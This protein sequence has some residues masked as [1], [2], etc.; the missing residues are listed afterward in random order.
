VV[1]LEFPEAWRFGSSLSQLIRR[2]LKNPHSDLPEGISR[3]GGAV[4]SDQFEKHFPEALL[5]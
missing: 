2:C 5:M 1:A 3:I 4:M